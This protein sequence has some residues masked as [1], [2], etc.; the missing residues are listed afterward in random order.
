MDQTVKIL[1][2]PI[3]QKLPGILEFQFYFWDPWTIY[4]KMLNV[5]FQEAFGNFE[6]E[7]KICLFL[8][9][10]A[11]PPYGSSFNIKCLNRCWV[12][13][14]VLQAVHS[15]TPKLNYPF[16]CS[17][18]LLIFHAWFHAVKFIAQLIWCSLWVRVWVPSIAVL[19]WKLSVLEIPLDKV[20]RN[21]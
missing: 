21:L 19:L 15:F 9:R 2:W 18:P 16:L 5:S 13:K 12:Y 8:G 3:T 14:I 1:F 4:Y 11:A 17:I 20:T 7:H 10:G 6:I